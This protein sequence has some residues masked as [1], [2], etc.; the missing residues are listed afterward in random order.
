MRMKKILFY[1][2]AVL[3]G[4]CVPI[5]SLRPLLTSEDLVFDEKLLG[6]WVQDVNDPS[7]AWRFTRLDEASIGR[8]ADRIEGEIDKA[9]RLDITD[10]GAHKGS[11][12]A[13]LV[14]LGD[15]HFLD[16][17]ADKLPSGQTDVE[18]AKLPFNA[19]FLLP[20]HTFIKVET[21]ADELK[22]RLTDD[23]KF[24]EL[25][26]AHPDAV[27]HEMIDDVPVLTASTRELQA[28][29]AKYADDERLFAN[30]IL[31]RRKAQ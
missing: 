20:T 25:I 17:F 4:G 31:L 7:D 21:I 11:L 15:R 26:E 24:Q 22:L 13:C 6:T 16:I 18:E 19:F 29:V 3:M 14:K 1:A 28:F 10:D 12:V 5:M 30:E 2:L 27:K 9:Y 23:E 8:L